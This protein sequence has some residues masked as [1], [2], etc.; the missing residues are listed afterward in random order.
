[1]Q[2]EQ[3]KYLIA[4]A[5]SNKQDK[6]AMSVALRTINKHTDAIVDLFLESGDG[7]LRLLH[8]FN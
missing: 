4:A 3:K 2:I 5:I 6:G 7:R 8:Y 1:M